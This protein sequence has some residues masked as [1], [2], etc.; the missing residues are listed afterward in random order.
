MLSLS[1][2]CGGK[3]PDLAGISGLSVLCLPPVD[4]E[5]SVSKPTVLPPMSVSTVSVSTL[6]LTVYKS[7]DK[8]NITMTYAEQL[9][10]LLVLGGITTNA[11]MGDPLEAALMWRFNSSWA[12]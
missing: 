2:R 6:K 4:D 8:Y 1:A 3:T 9:T 10:T 7:R 12:L 5:G 11:T